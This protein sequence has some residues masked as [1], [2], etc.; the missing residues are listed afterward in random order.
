MRICVFVC[1]LA[2]VCVC[3]WRARARLIRRCN[4]RVWRILCDDWGN[5]GGVSGGF[6]YCNL[7]RS[8]PPRP[9]VVPLPWCSV[10]CNVGAELPSADHP[11]PCVAAAAYVVQSLSRTA[12]GIT[13][14]SR[15]SRFR[16]S[17]PPPNCHGPFALCEVHRA[18]RRTRGIL[19][20]LLSER[21]RHWQVDYSSEHWALS[22]TARETGLRSCRRGDRAL[23]LHTRALVL[24][25]CGD[26]II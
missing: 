2:S 17:R 1:V 15:G 5:G 20:T 3:T 13:D 18:R 24:V 21:A 22:S 14:Y 19:A 25:F 10:R 8:P 23:V 11:C 7:T 9:K 4:Y 16:F 26:I 6:L 12:Y